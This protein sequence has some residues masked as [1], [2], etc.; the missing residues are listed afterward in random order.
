MNIFAVHPEPLP[1]A[2]SLCDQHVVK[3]AIESFQILSTVCRQ[4]G[5][6]APY[7]ATHGRHPCVLWAAE[8]R[9]NYDWL[10][11]H[12]IGLVLE[13]KRRYQKQHG[14]ARVIPWFLQHKPN[15]PE[16]VLTPFAQAMPD[17]CR[18]PDPI[19]A[20]RRFYR[21]EKRRFARWRLG[22][23]PTWFTSGQDQS[24]SHDYL[25]QSLP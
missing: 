24:C 5:M 6:E 14:T 9:Q 13:Y 23:V 25:Y 4:Q 12:G 10:L 22:N 3:M 20:Y 1:A 18:H 19:E 16:G 15:L 2:R 17:H 11:R 21:M 8:T 7:K